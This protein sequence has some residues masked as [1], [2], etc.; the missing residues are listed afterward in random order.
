LRLHQSA[1]DQIGEASALNSVGL[2]LFELG[3][4][5]EAI[6]HFERAL[7]LQVKL[8]QARGEAVTRVNL[9]RATGGSLAEAHLRRAGE[10]FRSVGD[11]Y[12]AARVDVEFAAIGLRGDGRYRIRE[13]LGAALAVMSALG[14]DK[15]LA[16][17]HRLLADLDADAGDQNSAQSHL[18][19]AVCH[20]DR[21]LPRPLIR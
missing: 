4:S 1:G 5:S 18:E 3:A 15:E 11:H 8:K 6:D 2:A 10:V 9:A 16:R 20:E 14:S 17:I 21:L 13:R 7:T 19:A 12:N